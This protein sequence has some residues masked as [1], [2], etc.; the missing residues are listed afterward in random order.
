VTEPFPVPIAPVETVIQA[1]LLVAVQLQ[2]LVD[3]TVTVPDPP[4]AGRV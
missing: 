2:L 4:L 1:A 3:V